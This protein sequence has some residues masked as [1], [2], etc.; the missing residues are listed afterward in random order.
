MDHLKVDIRL[1][2][3]VSVP[4][5]TRVGDAAVDLVA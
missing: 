3:G 1:D 5:Y 4:A 2:E